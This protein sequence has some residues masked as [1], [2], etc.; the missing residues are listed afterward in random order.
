[1]LVPVV[2][3]TATAAL[4]GQHWVG[5]SAMVLDEVAPKNRNG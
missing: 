2:K 4:D 1:M 3:W 5:I